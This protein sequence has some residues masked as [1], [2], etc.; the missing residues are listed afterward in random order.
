VKVVE[1]QHLE[2]SRDEAGG[3]RSMTMTSNPSLYVPGVGNTP[4]GDV[5]FHVY[6]TDDDRSCKVLPQRAYF[7]T[8]VC[9]PDS[10][11]AGIAEMEP[12]SLH[13]L[14]HAPGVTS[15]MWL[16]VML[17][18]DN[19]ARNGGCK[20]EVTCCMRVFRFWHQRASIV[21]VYVVAAELTSPLLHDPPA[22]GD[23]AEVL[24]GAVQVAVGHPRHRREDHAA[25]VPHRRGD[26]RGLLQPAGS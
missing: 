14:P 23:A 10:L 6:S 12:T 8:P 4:I 9:L 17:A 2:V 13:A 22:G 16:S 24:R 11:R 7:A 5:V 18:A 21:G 25:R 1:Q 3:M 19:T 20:V 15:L 26:L